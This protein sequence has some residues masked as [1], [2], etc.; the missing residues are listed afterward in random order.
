MIRKFVFL[1]GAAFA[2]SGITPA[3]GQNT[4]SADSVPPG[5]GEA[6]IIV[7]AT[8]REE[9]LQDVPLA[10]TALSAE[11]LRTRNIASIGDL[12]SGRVPGLAVTT[13]NGTDT[14]L[15]IYMRGFGPTDASQGTQDM[16]VALYIDGVNIPRAHGAGMDLVTPERIEVL[17]GPQGQLFGRNAHSGVVQIV[18]KRPSGEWEGDFSVSL[19][20][21]S[22]VQARGRL[23]LPEMAG[24]KVQLSGNFRRRDGYIHNPFNPNY[25]N[26]TFIP[27]PASH[28]KFFNRDFNGDYLALK[29]YGGRAAVERDFGDLN[30]FYSYD[31]TWARDDQGSN[32]FRRSD[33]VGTIFTGFSPVP[34]SDT[35]TFSNFSGP[36]GSQVFFSNKELGN[37]FPETARYGNP[38]FGFVT[39]S[40]GHILNLTYTASDN[41]TLRSITGQRTVTR[42][43]GNVQNA[44]VSQTSS[45]DYLK[46]KMFSQ[47]LQLIYTADDFNLTAGAL[48]FEEDVNHELANS[49][50][51]NCV[52]APP[53][54]GPRCVPGSSQASTGPTPVANFRRSLS[55]TEAYGLYAQGT[56]TIGPVDLK[57][58]V[59]YSRDTKIGRRPIDRGLGIDEPNGIGVARR[60]RF[61]TSRVDPAFT[62]KYNFSDDVNAYVRYA[63]GYRDGGSS[64]RSTTFSAFDEDEIESWEVGFKS[65]LFDRRLTFN[66]AAFHNTIKGQQISIQEQPLTNVALTNVINSVLDRKIKG[67][68]LELTA[69]LLPGLTVS[70]AYTYLKSNRILF[71]FD[72]ATLVPFAPNATFSPQTGLIPDAA[73]RAAHPGSQLLLVGPLGT[74]K[75]SGSINVDYVVP[76]GESNILFHVDWVRTSRF[77]N[78]SPEIARTNILADGTAVPLPGF[79]AGTSANRVNARVAFRDIPLTGSATGEFALWAKNLFD[80]LDRAFA[81]AAGINSVVVPAPPRVIGAEFR[82]KF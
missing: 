74:P 40:Q 69:N 47:E 31:N 49:N 67:F 17:R 62:A 5:R 82:V 26:V 18:S 53:V 68:E 51:N 9:R 46:S 6:D 76:A 52:T 3:Y 37:D 73:T 81:F 25:T 41:L 29:T 10:V 43:G 8:R 30:F 14:A 45:T 63:V 50:I 48:Y 4:T 7:T 55:R 57:A 1:A 75:H 59:R 33:K 70:G 20:M 77:V 58:G 64:V 13:L 21:Y 79:N 42:A 27:D 28:I 24:F 66:A 12:G 71:G 80:H 32:E 78:G 23:D 11:T 38:L 39:K 56:Y 34:L 72:I 22:T 2:A 15:S 16:P 61:H 35:I 60:N 65:Q 36:G 54:A 19:G 44:V